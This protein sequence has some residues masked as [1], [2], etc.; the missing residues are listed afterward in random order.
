MTGERLHYT[1]AD[2]DREGAVYI[3]RGRVK[4]T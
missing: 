3:I 4:Y 2:R 1:L